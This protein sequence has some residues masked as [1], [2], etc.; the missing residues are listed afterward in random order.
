M[1]RW[2]GESGIEKALDHRSLLRVRRVSA[3]RALLFPRFA[4]YL[5]GL[6]QVKPHP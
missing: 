1:W 3:K 4:V 2:I 5:A 6:V